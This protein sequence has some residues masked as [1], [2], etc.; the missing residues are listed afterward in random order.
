[1]TRACWKTVTLCAALA[2]EACFVDANVGTNVSSDAGSADQGIVDT[3][4]PGSEGA[5]EP[6]TAPPP[7]PPVDAGCGVS[8]AQ[9]GSWVD[10]QV[11]Q[12]VIPPGTGGDIVPGTYV[13]TALQAYLGGGTGTAQVR[14][15]LVVAGSPTVGTFSQLSEVRNTS[16][17][18]SS[19]PPEGSSAT[20][21]A[22]SNTAF[23]FATTTCGPP[24][25]QTNQYDATATTLTLFGNAIALSYQRVP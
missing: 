25:P 3:S 21:Q 10:L 23:L 9:Q 15:T 7:P 17:S 5:A 16:G 20:W 19:Q 11:V 6:D 22:D 24:F 18:F 14:E 2:S 12:Q 1:M 13:L 8:L 4:S